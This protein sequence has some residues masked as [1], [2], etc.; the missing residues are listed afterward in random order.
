MRFLLL[1][2]ASNG[3]HHHHRKIKLHNGNKMQKTDSA[4]TKNR[5]KKQATTKQ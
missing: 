2:L 3:D 1:L 5:D 4:K